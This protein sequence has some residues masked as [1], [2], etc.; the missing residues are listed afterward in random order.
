LPEHKSHHPASGIFILSRRRPL[1]WWIIQVVK[2]EFADYVSDHNV[3]LVGSP[4]LS[5]PFPS[6]PSAV[7]GQIVGETL[8]GVLD[9]TSAAGQN[10]E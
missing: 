9:L 10:I 1:N 7:N 3:V 5:V 8:L 4:G 2:F 6:E